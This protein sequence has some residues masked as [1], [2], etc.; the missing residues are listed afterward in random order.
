M[1]VPP[2]YPLL[3]GIFPNKNQPFEGTPIYGNPHIMM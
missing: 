3:D 2:N 1:G